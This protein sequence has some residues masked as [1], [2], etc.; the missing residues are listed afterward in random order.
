MIKQVVESSL[1]DSV[2]GDTAKED[3]CKIL[4]NAAQAVFDDPEEGD[5]DL[6]SPV[7][8]II[9]IRVL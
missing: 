6:V 1:A 4:G 5:D 9:G 7:T 3:V 2:I 8:Y